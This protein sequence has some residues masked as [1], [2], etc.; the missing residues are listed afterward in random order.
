V[1]G[2]FGEDTSITL[3]YQAIRAKSWNNRWYIQQGWTWMADADISASF[4]SIDAVL[5]GMDGAGVID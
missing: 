5:R 3:S 1:D 4:W 2:V